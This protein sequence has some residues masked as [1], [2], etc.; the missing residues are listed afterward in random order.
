L[1]ADPLPPIEGRLNV[2]EE[3]DTL[4]AT[5]IV[6]LKKLADQLSVQDLV[7]WEDVKLRKWMGRR[8]VGAFIRSNF[9]TMSAILVLV[10]LDE[11]NIGWH[12]VT[13]GDRII[14]NQVIM[15]LLGATTVQVGT[16]AV[17]IARYLF[18]VRPQPS[19]E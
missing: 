12:L 5:G 6:S 4:A 15:T 9:V 17:I 2:T 7:A 13:P 3:D 16:I 11:I 8:I 10:M 14:T 1:P 19:R 18:P